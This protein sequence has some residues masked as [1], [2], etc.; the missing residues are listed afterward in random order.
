MLNGAHLVWVHMCHTVNVEKKKTSRI[1]NAGERPEP[2]TPRVSEVTSG[3]DFDEFDDVQR[4]H[5]HGWDQVTRCGL[6]PV[7]GDLLEPWERH[8]KPHNP[9]NGSNGG[10]WIFNTAGSTFFHIT[11]SESFVGIYEP[12]NLAFAWCR[13]TG[14]WC[15]GGKCEWQSRSCSRAVDSNFFVGY[16]VGFCGFEFLRAP[17]LSSV[18]G[19]G[20]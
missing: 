13:F 5:G 8:K 18:G 4:F 15:T 1:P 3:R 10:E 6:S 19:S 17:D 11:S 16:W 9:S 14:D 20:W 2:F 12:L 7:F